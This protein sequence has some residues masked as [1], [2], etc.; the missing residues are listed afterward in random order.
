MKKNPFKKQSLMDTLTNVG[1][2]GASN[3][4]FDYIWDAAGLDATLTFES[5]SADTIKNGIKILGGALAG[6]MISNKYGRAAADGIATVGVSNLVSGLITGSDTD[7][8]KTG[9]ETTGLPSGTVGRIGRR[10][11]SAAYARGRRSGKIAGD[12]IAAD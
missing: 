12:F 10:Y 11:G 4:A 2:G 6:G 7:K 8:P 1:I 5:V 3:V 9:G